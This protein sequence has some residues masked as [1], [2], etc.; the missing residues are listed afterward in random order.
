M[1]QAKCRLFSF[2]E[3]E[4]ATVVL[5]AAVASL[6]TARVKQTMARKSA[7]SNVEKRA[8]S[9]SEEIA[10]GPKRSE[11]LWMA[12]LVVLLHSSGPVHP[13]HFERFPDPLMVE[14]VGKRGFPKDFF[15][16][17]FFYFPNLCF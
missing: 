16:I 6:E 1:L 17:F 4:P 14:Q 2:Y 7:T 10:E 11:F 9:G 5:R 13:V 12:L 8:G 15:G 3:N